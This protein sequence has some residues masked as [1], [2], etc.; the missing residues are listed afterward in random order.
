MPII[1][2]NKST[3]FGLTES[4]ST[5]TTSISDEANDRLAKQGDL[6][7]LT[8]DVKETLVGAVNEVKAQ[9]TATADSALAKDQNLAD[10]TDV[11]VARTNLAVYS[12]E[13]VDSAIDMAKLA[14]GTIYNVADIA[15]RDAL[16][17]LDLADR[18]FVTDD[19]DGKWA[20]YKPTTI[21]AELGTVTEWLKIYDQDS[22]ENSLSAEGV[23][24]AYESNDDTNAYA[25]ADK[26][27][28]DLVTVTQAIDLDDAVL[29]S[30]LVADIDVSPAA[31]QPATAAA[32]KAYVD[33]SMSSGGGLPTMETLVVAGDDITLTNAP[34]GG[35][36][37]VLNFATVRYIDENGVAW[38]APLLPTADPKV[39]TV[40][41][42]SA[43]QWDTNSVQIQYFYSPG[44]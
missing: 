43:G 36:N 38:D 8:T 37:G 31:A 35:I 1:K 15:E 2:R 22:L 5:L 19:G 10:V 7:A 20:Q 21:D 40:S 26:A 6:T 23:K 14:L 32:V 27:K 4:L 16:A 44:A 28:V 9:A 17:D 33:S 18:V 3:I 12:A 11:A 25:D 39:F 34:R 29:A 42:D 30:N 13:E 24:A 41:V